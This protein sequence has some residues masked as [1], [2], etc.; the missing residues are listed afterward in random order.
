[1]MTP[2]SIEIGDD[3]NISTCEKHGESSSNGHG[4]VYKN[5]DAYSIY[6]AGWSAASA[7]KCVS[8]ALAIG[9]WDDDSSS[10]DRTCFGLEVYE[11]DDEIQFRVCEPEE[12]PWPNT[13]LLGQMV[14][15]DV[16]LKHDL[17]KEVYLIAEEVLHAIKKPPF[18]LLILLI[19]FKI[20][21]SL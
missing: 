20:R 19:R 6:Y 14:S 12:S 2:Y 10:E 3:E 1:M 17:L 21:R 11:T 9:E 4:F 15:R 8:L 13:D 16:G 7:D 5:N 18:F